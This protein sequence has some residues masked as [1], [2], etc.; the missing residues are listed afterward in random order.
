MLSQEGT[1]FQ[2]TWRQFLDSLPRTSFLLVAVSLVDLGL[3][4]AYCVWSVNRP[5]G[6][7]EESLHIAVALGVRVNAAVIRTEPARCQPRSAS[8]QCNVTILAGS[9]EPLLC[10]CGS[11][12]PP[13]LA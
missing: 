6:A 13:N 2:D 1:P 4:I 5:A 9:L 3:V 11:R 7:I 10:L 12:C 8:F